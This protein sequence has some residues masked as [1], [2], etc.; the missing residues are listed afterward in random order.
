MI[1]IINQLLLS[2]F[3]KRSVLLLIFLTI[4]WLQEN[5][6]TD[7]SLYYSTP[8]FIY[9][10]RK[11]IYP[12]TA[13]QVTVAEC[14]ISLASRSRVWTLKKVTRVTSITL[15][16]ATHRAENITFKCFRWCG[17]ADRETAQVRAEIEV[18]NGDVRSKCHA[19]HT[20]EYNLR[21]VNRHI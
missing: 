21:W 15:T 12:T 10:F 3:S 9:G 6:L 16:S 11:N 13:S 14:I 19:S 18:I 1:F 2:K 8:F 20:L 4:T 7:T 5:L 17:F